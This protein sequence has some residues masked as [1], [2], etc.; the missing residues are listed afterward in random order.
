MAE[1]SGKA[2]A[3]LPKKDFAEPEKPRLSDR[4]Q[5]AVLNKT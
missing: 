1:L 3:M 4:R 2:R 5:T